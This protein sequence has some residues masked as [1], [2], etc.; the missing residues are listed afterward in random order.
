MSASAR[1][2]KSKHLVIALPASL[3][4]PRNP[5]VKAALM[6]QAGKHEKTRKAERR[7]AK[8]SLARHL[9]N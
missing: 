6:R 8:T 5:L 3:V 9:E 1:S 7:Q 2:I 4:K